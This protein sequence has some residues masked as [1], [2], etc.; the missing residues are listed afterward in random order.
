M[1]ERPL[2]FAMV[3]TFY[4]PYHFGGDAVFVQRLAEALAD[5]GH[6]V[7]VVHSVDAYR[8]QA[9]GEPA[10]WRDD[11]PRVRRHAL[12]SRHPRLFAALTHQRGGPAAYARRLREVLDRDYDVIH[13]HNVSL[14]GGP[15]VLGLGRAVK[16]Y[17]AHE[18]WLVCPT[19]VLFAFD[20]AACTA[21]QCLPCVLSHRRVPQAW[22]YTGRLARALEGV[23]RLLMPS[24]FALE[25]HAAD[26]IA[27]PMVHL[28]HF[29]PDA[30]EPADPGAA[31]PGA[32]AGRPLPSRP[33]FLYVGRLERLKGVED[34]LRLFEDDPGADLVIAGDGSFR[35]ALEARARGRS[36]VHFLG[37]VPPARLGALYRQAVA[38]LVPSLCYET[39]G[40]AAAEAMSHGTPAIVRRIGALAEMVAESGGGLAFD[41]LDECRAA[42]H[43][44]LAQAGLRAELGGRGRACARER[45]SRRAHLRA[46]LA[47]A[48]ALLAER[49]P[50]R[51]DRAGA[52]GLAPLAAASSLAPAPLP[53][54]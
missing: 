48:R 3:T 20:R 25:R 45:W 50:A 46:Y 47:L 35:A 32:G 40:L 23:D 7:D 41:T 8:V 27:R 26:G 54:E 14:A 17:T 13:F 51:A 2:R 9:A 53:A 37:T 21:R 29:V 43:R 6:E 39:F 15:D 22:R 18:Y 24:R 36:R 38:L 49:D 52:P 34:L 1:P 31:A 44:L 30:D 28:P 16:L 33:F 11:H 5:A 4:P 42:M 10:A 12:Q 19:H